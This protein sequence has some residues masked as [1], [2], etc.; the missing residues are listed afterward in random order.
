M[1][2]VSQLHYATPPYTHTST[3]ARLEQCQSVVLQPPPASYFFDYTTEVLLRVGH[4]T[5]CR[6]CTTAM[7]TATDATLVQS[8]L[9]HT[10][11]MLP[12][13]GH[14]IISYLIV[15]QGIRILFHVCCHPSISGS[16]NRGCSCHPMSDDTHL[17]KGAPVAFYF[18]P[19]QPLLSLLPRVVLRCF[20]A[21]SA[22]VLFS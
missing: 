10:S 14:L 15:R 22:L 5:G 12:S 21:A 6:K 8:T 1:V 11:S 4:R 20:V 9:R 17:L 16:R 19:S 3:S 18:L 13:P 2:P 7:L